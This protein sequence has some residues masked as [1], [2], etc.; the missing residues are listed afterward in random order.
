MGIIATL[1]ALALRASK[2]KHLAMVI[3]SAIE[4][5]EQALPEVEGVEKTGP[6]KLRIA[7]QIIGD[8]W[9]EFADAFGT[10]DNFRP[11]LIERINSTVAAWR[12]LQ[13]LRGASK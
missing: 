5:A 8:E 10:F 6:Q 1:T 9:D 13:A 2:Y 3:R 12:E 4:A 11:K 7:L